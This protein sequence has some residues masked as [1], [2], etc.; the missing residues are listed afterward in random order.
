[1][2]KLLTTA[3]I[4]S[5]LLTANA[6]AD[7]KGKDSEFGKGQP[8]PTKIYRKLD[9]T[10]AQEE[11]IKAIFRAVKLDKQ[12]EARMQDRAVDR[13]QHRA[14]IEAK[15]F[16]TAAAKKLADA[17]AQKMSERFVRM[18]EAEHKAWQVLTPEQ[19]AKAKELMKKR[20][21]RMEKRMAKRSEKKANK[22]D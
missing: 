16:D 3:L 5:T 20:A 21:E 19:Q 22:D 4:T 12:P 18:T 7:K 10:D 9:L 15:T 14:L 1:M 2:K 13:Q 11:K 17:K 8:N 6:F